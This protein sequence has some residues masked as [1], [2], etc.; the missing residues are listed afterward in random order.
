MGSEKTVEK[1]A[2]NENKLKLFIFLQIFTPNFDFSYLIYKIAL[3]LKILVYLH[4]PK[5]I[6]NHP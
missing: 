5:R 4:P 6:G 3:K 1:I 2:F